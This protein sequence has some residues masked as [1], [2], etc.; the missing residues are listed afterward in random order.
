VNITRNPTREV[1]VGNSK[2]GNNNPILVQ[3]MC[4]T[5]TQD[6]DATIEQTN[7]LHE[8]KAGVVRIAVDMQYCRLIYKK[9]IAWQ[10]W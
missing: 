2:I 10:H 5:R 7:A 3:S 1:A 6:I 8:R 4:A 9:I